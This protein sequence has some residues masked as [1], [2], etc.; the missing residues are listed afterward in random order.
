MSEIRIMWTLLIA[1]Y[2]GITQ[3]FVSHAEY[4]LLFFYSTLQST[5]SFYFGRTD[6]PPKKIMG[7]KVDN[8]PDGMW[9]QDI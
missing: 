5:A 4:F 3:W 7:Q 6:E 8:F 2:L 9:Y 1:R